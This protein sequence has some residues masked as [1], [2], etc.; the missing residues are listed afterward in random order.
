MDSATPAYPATLETD[1]DGRTV[2]TFH[3][4]TGRPYGRQN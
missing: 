3:D 1:T 2:V 4:L